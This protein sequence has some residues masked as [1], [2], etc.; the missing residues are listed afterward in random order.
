MRTRV[1]VVTVILFLF[2]SELNARIAE[3][4]R[5]DARAIKKLVAASRGRVVL[6]N[7]WAT[8]CAPCIE[9]FPDLMKLRKK[10]DRKGLDVYLVSVDDTRKVSGTVEP[11]L[12]RMKVDFPT[13]VKETDDDD[14]FIAAIHPGWSGAIPAT[15]V[16][17]RE[18]RLVHV[19]ID[20]QTFEELERV[21]VPLLSP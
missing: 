13:Y 1:L 6:I 21:V 2:G 10:Y 16:Y 20:S 14:A 19:L 4:S 11:F 5:V 7:F 15:F 12:R 18:G 17:D 3:V 9:E 8:W